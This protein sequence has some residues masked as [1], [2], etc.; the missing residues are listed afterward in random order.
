M[1][2]ELDA[3]NVAPEAKELFAEIVRRHAAQ[4]G[5][6]AVEC[7]ARVI[8]ARELLDQGADRSIICERLMTRY[9]VRRSTAYAD[10]GKAL[11]CPISDQISG[12]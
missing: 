6:R 7:R 10:I 3:A 1:L 9:G 11:N 12:R 4:E 8:Y 2:Q 5:V